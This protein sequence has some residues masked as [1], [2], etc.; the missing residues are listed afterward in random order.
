KRVIPA[1]TVNGA[2][3]G[4]RLAEA[5]LEAGL[6]IIEITF[7]TEAAAE[8]IKAIT[9][10]F[11]EM[12]VGAGTVLETEQLKRAI[13]SGIA[14]G[15]APGLNEKLVEAA[16][17]LGMPF[18][19][20]VMTPSEIDR[21]I[22]MDCNLLKF[23]PAEA[24]GGARTLKAF[25]GPFSHTGVKFVPTGGVSPSNAPGY[26]ELAVVAAVGGSWMVKKD[27]VAGGKWK[28]ITKLSREALELAATG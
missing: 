6:D 4:V 9:E 11:P 1:A 21:A 24:M 13:D 14:F 12:L 3:E 10:K 8:A 22:R 17:G 27:L 16:A 23:F 5:L 18:V 2:E 19:P 7:R 15:V 26:L 28:E 25:A 20:G